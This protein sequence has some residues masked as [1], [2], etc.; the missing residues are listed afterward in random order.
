M[1]YFDHSATTPVHPDVLD[2]MHSIQKNVYGNPSSVH[3]Q[4][5]KAKSLIETARKQIANTIGAN[6]NHII[7]TSGGTEA[8]KFFGL[9]F[10]KKKNMLSQIR[11]NIQPF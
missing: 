1:Y 11:L 3:S 10:V 9:F 2:L 7:F 6:P 4:G 8:I 5:K